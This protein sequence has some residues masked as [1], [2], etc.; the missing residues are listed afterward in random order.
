MGYRIFKSLFIF[1]SWMTAKIID[2][3]ITRTHN[4]SF[5]GY[6]RYYAEVKILEHLNEAK[7]LLKKYKSY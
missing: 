1:Q 2:W 5:N 4:R 6:K 3:A 7:E